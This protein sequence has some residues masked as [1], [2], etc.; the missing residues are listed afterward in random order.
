MP[1]RSLAAG[2][3]LLRIFDDGIK[4]LCLHGLDGRLDFPKGRCDD[5][6]LNMFYTAQREC[7]EESSIVV[8]QN[9]I[10]SHVPIL[11]DRLTLFCA[12]TDQEAEIR[13]NPESK[14]YEHAG[15][16]WLDPLEAEFLLPEYLRP[17]ITWAWN[18]AKAYLTMTPGG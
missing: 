10:I 18:I 11:L 9:D 5:A 12:I 8:S 2:F 7:L 4:V 16:D 15:Y 13:K 1:D 3:V 17:A 6:D 14:K